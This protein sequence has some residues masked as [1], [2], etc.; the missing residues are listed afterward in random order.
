MSQILRVLRDTRRTTY[1]GQSS[2]SVITRLAEMAIL[3]SND[4]MITESRNYYL[5]TAKNSIALCKP[6]V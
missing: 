3:P 4:L 1:T 6:D 2:F 5:I